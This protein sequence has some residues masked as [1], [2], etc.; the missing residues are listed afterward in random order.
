VCALE[1]AVV[2]LIKIIVYQF[3]GGPEKNHEKTFIVPA[4]I[5]TK[6]LLN[7]SLQ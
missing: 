4:E 7:T 3:S 6:D 2:V 1:R 5:Q